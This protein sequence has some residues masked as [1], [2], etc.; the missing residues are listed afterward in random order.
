MSFGPF[1][2]KPFT[3]WKSVSAK[4]DPA[5]GNRAA[6]AKPPRSV[7]RARI[8][9]TNASKHSPLSEAAASS[10]ADGGSASQPDS[11]KQAFSNLATIASSLSA[12]TDK[13]PDTNE[14]KMNTL[15]ELLALDVFED[16]DEKMRC[17]Q[18]LK[19]LLQEKLARL[20]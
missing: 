10:A 17:K 9:A 11:A 6:V 5:V 20:S 2:S 7:V 3:E 14:A 13:K 4:A 1:S 16:E 15:K 19:K 18:Q 12:F 8:A